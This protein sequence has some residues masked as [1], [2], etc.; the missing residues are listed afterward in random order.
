MSRLAD[1]MPSLARKYF[2]S[3]VPR[4]ILSSTFQI[5]HFS[6]VRYFLTKYH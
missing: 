1:L 4:A 3:P 6:D 5:F 2:H